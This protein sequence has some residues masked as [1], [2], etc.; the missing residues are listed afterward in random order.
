MG[1]FRGHSLVG[2]AFLLYGLMWSIRY[3]MV[4]LRGAAHGR[5]WH[6]MDLVE[7][8]FKFIFA[9]IGAVM[10]NFAP[11]IGPRFHLINPEDHSWVGLSGWLHTTMYIFFS[12]SGLVDILTYSPLKIP[13]GLDRLTLA[14]AFSLEGLL[15]YNHVRSQQPLEGLL[16]A[17]VLV[18]ACIGFFC[19]VAEIFMRG[20]IIL[21]LFRSILAILQ[22]SWLWQIALAV[23]PLRGAPWD[24][25]DR[26][27]LE[28]VPIC[29]SWHLA[30][31]II[32]VITNYS[33]VHCYV[34]KYKKSS[35]TNKIEF[36][37]L[38]SAPE[39]LEIRL[40]EESDEEY[41]GRTNRQL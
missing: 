1:D 7:G 24:Q 32:I 6:R 12:L 40:L 25:K 9:S 20:H 13:Q 27:N 10:E 30:M 41:P 21:E 11:S 19:L 23:H 18:V 34:M 28:F 35:A 5:H 26:S 33:L 8:I 16:H 29:F 39:E 31:A 37:K 3:P 4:Y 36:Q 38:G 2:S 14:L 22:G 17:F 15:M